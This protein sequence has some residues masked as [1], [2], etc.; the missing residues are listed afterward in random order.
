LYAYNY[1]IY[2]WYCSCTYCILFSLYWH[3]FWYCYYA[4]KHLALAF[5]P[6]VET[7]PL[8]KMWLG[9]IAFLFT[10][11]INLDKSNQILFVTYTWLADVN[12]S[13]VKCLCF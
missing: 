13:V 1:L 10:L 3:C 9:V 2:H 5:T 4:S 8:S 12:A 7:H 11:P 6:S